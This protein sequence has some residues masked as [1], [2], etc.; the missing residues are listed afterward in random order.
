MM[1]N[2]KYGPMDEVFLDKATPR[3][4]NEEHIIEAVEYRLKTSGE[5]VHRSAHMTLKS[6]PETGAASAIGRF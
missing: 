3:E 4:E 6:S 2:T 5:L 1:I